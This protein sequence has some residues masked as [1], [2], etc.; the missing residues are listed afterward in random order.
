MY[1]IKTIICFLDIDG[2]LNNK[3]FLLNNPG[4]EINPECIQLLNKLLKE[5]NASVV[6]SSSWRI[7]QSIY[8][9]QN[10]L[11]KVGFK[12]PERIIGATIS[13]SKGQRGDEID[14]WLRQI[15][16]DAF[17]ILDDDDDMN[18]VQDMLVQTSFETGLLEEHVEKAKQIIAKQLRNESSTST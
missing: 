2:V 12:Y 5:T 17:V 16:V 7:G 14:L 4:L 8:W 18:V 15:H 3:S 9:L 10:M 1:N 11:E 6:I 13:D